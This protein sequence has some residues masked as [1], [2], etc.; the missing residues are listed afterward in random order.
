MHP[1]GSL[2]YAF[3]YHRP[4]S[5]TAGSAFSFTV[6]SR[7]HFDNAVTS[8]NGTV[9]FTSNDGQAVLPTDST[10]TNGAGTL[11]ATL[12]TAGSQTLRATDTT[13]SSVTGT[14]NSI[15]VTAASAIDLRVIAPA[16]ATAATAFRF[17]VR[18]SGF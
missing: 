2:G 10:L 3:H 6:T 9:H 8:Y 5:A 4:A 1:S 14:S 11:S 7:D 17:T 12:K 16:T 18:R 15:A 13:N